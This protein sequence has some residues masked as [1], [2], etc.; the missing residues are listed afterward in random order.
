MSGKSKRNVRNNVS[1]FP[2]EHHW[3]KG[4]REK[5]EADR[6]AL[7]EKIVTIHKG[8][9][10]TYGSP[11]IY[12]DLKARGE[13]CSKSTIERLMHKNAIRA[14]TKRKFKATT[15][16]KHSHPVAEN[17]L[18]RAFDVNTPNKVWCADITYIWTGEGWLYL[19]TVLD[20]Y[21]RK[22]VGWSMKDR[23]TQDLALDALDMAHKRRNP[24]IGLLHHSDRGSQY[25]A[26]AYARR[27]WRYGM[28]Q[29]MSRKGN[30]W[31]N[32]AMES[33]FHTLKTEM[34]FHEEFKTREQARQAV[35]EW[36]EVFYNRQRIHSTI[37]FKSPEC[38]EQGFSRTI[39]A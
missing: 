14:K 6:N 3:I 24:P 21:S 29:S 2:G 35:F 13:C 25:A 17:L 38:Y 28:T 26:K 22:V 4:R 10:G 12:R 11:R 31:D 18:N 16:S 39:A 8:S 23:M 19:A 30:C 20:L 15:N 7:L 36:I 32:A 1:V 27:L 33:F 5:R 37:G 9:R 34:I